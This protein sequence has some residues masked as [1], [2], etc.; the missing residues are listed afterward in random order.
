MTTNHISFANNFLVFQIFVTIR[1]INDNNA[2][3]YE[4]NK[5]QNIKRTIFIH[6]YRYKYNMPVVD[7][8]SRNLI[9]N[10][11]NIERNQDKFLAYY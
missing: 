2:N 4:N 8:T 10:I 6:F 5:K 11:N 7:T 9:A 3:L 1:H